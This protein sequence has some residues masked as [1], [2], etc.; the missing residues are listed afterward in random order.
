MDEG[1]EEE[2]VEDDY[3][4]SSIGWMGYTIYNYTVRIGN[5]PDAL[6][7][8]GAEQCCSQLISGAEE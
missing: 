7:I 8:T 6:S 4:G 5:G 3:D 2:E 1:E